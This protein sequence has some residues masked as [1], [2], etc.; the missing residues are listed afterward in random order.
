MQSFHSWV[1]NIIKTGI[2]EN[3]KL[4]EPGTELLSSIALFLTTVCTE[5]SIRHVSHAH[6][7]FIQ[8]SV[9][10]GLNVHPFIPY[11]PPSPQPAPHNEVRLAIF[12]FNFPRFF[13]IIS[14]RSLGT[15]FI[16]VVSESLLVGV[17]LPELVVPPIP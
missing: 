9:T 7:P 10:V 16:V 3:R 11:W 6:Y 12:L 14:S 5:T 15:L 2:T 13:L 8:V 17:V 4:V 1:W